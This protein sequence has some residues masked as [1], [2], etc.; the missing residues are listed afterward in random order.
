MESQRSRQI[1]ENKG[2]VKRG[3]LQF[4]RMIVFIGAAFW[5]T[6]WLITNE[7]FTLADL[8]QAGVPI[9]VP[10]L[11]VQLGI[12]LVITFVFQIIYFIVYL[13]ISPAGRQRTG[14]ARHDGGER[15]PFDD[16]KS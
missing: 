4:L 9:S 2:V 7:Y 1:K 3:F 13:W 10:P 12:A 8:Y 15:N 11:F 14:Y 5:L 16:W 6:Q